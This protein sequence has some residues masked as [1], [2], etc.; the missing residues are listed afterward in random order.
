MDKDR[1]REGVGRKQTK[2]RGDN[3]MNTKKFEKESLRYRH[4]VKTE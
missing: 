4:T 3:N 2:K 1:E